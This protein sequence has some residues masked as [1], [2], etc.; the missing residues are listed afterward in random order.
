MQQLELTS[1]KRQN[2]SYAA[3]PALGVRGAA[4]TFGPV[5][6]GAAARVVSELRARRAA[7][8]GGAGGARGAARPAGAR[9]AASARRRRARRRPAQA[10]GFHAARAHR[11]PAYLLQ[12]IL[13]QTRILLHV[14]NSKATQTLSLQII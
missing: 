2:S 13:R 5:V 14:V 4:L 3:S 12:D 7:V 10:T 11:T 6:A 8:A 1:P 9:G